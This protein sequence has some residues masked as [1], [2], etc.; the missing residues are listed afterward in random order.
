MISGPRFGAPLSPAPSPDTHTLTTFAHVRIRNRQ[1]G[2][3]QARA[4]RQMCAHSPT[5]TQVLA[6]HLLLPPHFVRDTHSQIKESDFYGLQC[7]VQP[8]IL[9]LAVFIMILNKDPLK[10]SMRAVFLFTAIGPNLCF[11]HRF[12]GAKKKIVKLHGG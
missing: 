9:I 2:A 3:T 11:V 5:K 8:C 7:T 4:R 10:E 6:A 1:E 12:A